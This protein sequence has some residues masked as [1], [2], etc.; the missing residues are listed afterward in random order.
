MPA[1][2]IA[3]G[4]WSKTTEILRYLCFC[5]GVSLPGFARPTQR[6]EGTGGVCQVFVL[7]VDDFVFAPEAGFFVGC[8]CMMYV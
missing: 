3:A 2:F 7:V 8:V 6:N 4:F 1:L 5:E